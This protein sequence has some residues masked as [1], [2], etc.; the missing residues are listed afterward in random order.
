[1]RN[2]I[3]CGCCHSNRSGREGERHVYRRVVPLVLTP[4][5]GAVVQR[6]RAL[7]DFARSQGYRVG[8]VVEMIESVA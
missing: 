5:R 3:S 2:R 8:E 1:M 7:V 4:E 6:A